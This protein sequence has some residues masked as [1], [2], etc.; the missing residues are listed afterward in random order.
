MEYTDKY[1]NLHAESYWRIEDIR[2][3]VKGQSCVFTLR[4]Y[5]NAACRT[6]NKEPL[7]KIE[8]FVGGPNF[9]TY[10]SQEMNKTKNLAQIGYEVAKTWVNNGMGSGGEG[11]PFF[12]NSTDL[13]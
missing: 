3:N 4:A 8:V 12:Q 10:Y 1:G 13:L 2:I 9:L 6:G 7:E 11:E 5:K